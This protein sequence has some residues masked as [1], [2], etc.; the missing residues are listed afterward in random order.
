V[1]TW[2][3][4]LAALADQ[5]ERAARFDRPWAHA[6]VASLRVTG[7][8]DRVEALVM[9]P[10]GRT[11]RVKARCAIAAMPLFVLQH[12]LEEPERHGF[13]GS[14]DVP[15]YASWLVSNFLLHAFP[16]ERDGV[17]LAWDNVVYNEPGLGYVVSTHQEIRMSRPER[18]AFTAYHALSDMTPAAARHW[19][20]QASV[21]DLTQ[22]A[23]RDLRL[24][25]GWRLPLCV[26]RVAIT[27][28][29]HGMAVPMP[30]FLAA[31][32]RQ[33]LRNSQGPIFFAH[34][35]L[36]GMSLFEEAAWWGY[37]AAARA[38]ATN[39]RVNR[40]AHSV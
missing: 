40:S 33:A 2:P 24:A 15:A 38:I 17:G 29:G 12:V 19:L 34:S 22:I 11:V 27:V 8:D 16:E 5:L 31:P 10:E 6:S 3:Q 13:T 18:T 21:A 36:S 37:Q 9:L 7:D 35:D 14:R 23:S 1:L 39:A 26:D 28:R 30:G 32:G 4:G 20:E 25:Y